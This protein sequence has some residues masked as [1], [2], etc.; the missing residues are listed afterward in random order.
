M[1][2]LAI[3]AEQAE[4]YGFQYIVLLDSEEVSGT[5]RRASP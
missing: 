1:N 5:K 4:Q 3:G 2:A